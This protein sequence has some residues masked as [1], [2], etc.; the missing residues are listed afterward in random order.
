[1]MGDGVYELEEWGEWQGGSGPRGGRSLL[2]SSSGCVKARLHKVIAAVLI[3][4]VGEG[5]GQLSS[6]A[7]VYPDLP[8]Q[9]LPWITG[10]HRY[11]DFAHR[12]SDLRADL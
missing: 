5:L 3:S 11:P 4:S 9:L 1:M 10:S 8:I 7:Q 6:A 2:G 12:H